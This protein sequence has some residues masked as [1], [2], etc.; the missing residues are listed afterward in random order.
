[1]CPEAP[2]FEGQ[3]RERSRTR[4]KP[5]PMYKVL[6]HNDDYTTMEFVVWILQAV[7]HKGLAEATRIMWNVHR[8]GLG[9]CGAYP[10]DIAE[11]KVRQVLDLAQKEGYPLK[12]SMEP[13]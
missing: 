5:P 9:V 12:S 4:T 11:T 3:V 6:L 8:Q 2:D 13:E 7:F 1:M 10:R